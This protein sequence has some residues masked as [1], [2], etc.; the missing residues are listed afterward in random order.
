MIDEP[1]NPETDDDDD[2]LDFEDFDE[3]G[4][5]TGYGG[6]GKGT[7]GDLWRNNPMVKV[8]VILAAFAFV[9]GAIILF[10][11]KSERTPSSRVANSSSVTEAPGTSEVS[12]AYRQA[13]EEENVRRA[14]VALQESESVVP[15]PVDP[16]KGTLPLQLD[17]P[18]EEDPLER[19]KRLQEERIQQQQIVA[20]DISEPEPEPEVDTR[21]PAVN[22]LSQAMSVQMEAVLQNQQIK[23]VQ[24]RQVTS[25]SY[26]E[27]IQERERQERERQLALLQQQQVQDTEQAAT[28]LIPAGT[29]EYAQLITEANTDA[30]GAV[31]AQIISGPLQGS[32]LIGTFAATR[33]YL[34]LNFNTVVVDGVSLAISAVAIDPD[35]TLPG[36]V[37]DVDRRY[38]ERI[39][40]P[41]A[42]AF[43]EGL[44]DAISNSGTT[45]VFIEGDTV[46]ESTSDQD[47]REEVASGVSEA[48]SAAAELLQEEADAIQPMLK[49]AA[50]TPMGVLFIQPV[51]EGGQEPLPA[52]IQQDVQ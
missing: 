22:A 12:E 32:R 29:I 18:E 13:V 2:D 48:G 43:V 33:N 3:T 5:D 44:T 14:E 49:I 34:T 47:T 24:T 7:L 10:G 6:E 39:A 38:F 45:T 1:E 27:A 11:G 15:T 9:V 17:E 37:T 52:Q 4:F 16:P 26:L 46:S 51:I 31:L 8:G 28:I 36:L 19:W 50:G 23:P 21:T 42:A 35:T 40:L 20:E 30:P 41:M 25:M